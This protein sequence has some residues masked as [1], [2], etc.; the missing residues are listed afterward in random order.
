MK[1][2]AKV[3]RVDSPDGDPENYIESPT[4]FLRRL[5]LFNKEGN[6][7]F[8]GKGNHPESTFEEKFG[9]HIFLVQSHNDHVYVRLTDK[10]R[11]K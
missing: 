3:V 8:A 4:G 2:T 11:I 10:I 7:V 6:C 9:N 5:L 1:L